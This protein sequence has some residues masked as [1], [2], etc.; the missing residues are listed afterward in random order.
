M[1]YIYTKLMS[2]AIGEAL[3]NSDR[4]RVMAVSLAG[5][6]FTHILAACAVCNQILTP[7][8]VR[9]LTIAIGGFAVTMVAS[10]SHRDVGAPGQEVPGAA[11]VVPATVTGATAKVGAFLLLGLLGAVSLH[12]DGTELIATIN[13]SASGTLYLVDHTG[14]LVK[15]NASLYGADIVVGAVQVSGTVATPTIFAGLGAGMVQDSSLN[16]Q[17]LYGKV[18]V[19]YWLFNAFLAYDGLYPRIGA[20]VTAP[21]TLLTGTYK[22]IKTNF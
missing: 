5:I 15:D 19:G 9:D 17:R 1:N 22:V 6:I 7:D 11:P 2:F 21:L 18:M 14:N 3:G 8:V 10:L 13:P 20:G 16:S 4:V 12:A